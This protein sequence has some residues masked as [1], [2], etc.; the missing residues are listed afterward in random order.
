LERR[1]YRS[2]FQDG[3]WD[4]YLAGFMAIL[5]ILGLAHFRDGST[6]IWMIG[7]LVGIGGIFI[8]FMLGKKYI[9]VPRLGTAKFGPARK[10][11]KL[12]LVV[13]LSVSVLFNVVVLLITMGI[14]KA[15][16]WLQS[17]GDNLTQRG[18]MDVFISLFAGLFVTVIMCLIAYFIEFYR[19]MYIAFLFGLCIFID[20]FFDLPVA[21][22]VGE[23]L[24]AIPGLVLFIRFIKQYPIQRGLVENGNPKTN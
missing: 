23:A 12:G 17:F 8:L 21:M 24:A 4:L 6:W 2:T 15:P 20:M 13:I 5:G 16:V 22:L 19:G 11:R 1:A 18:V 7:Y 14:I 10:R 9:T 3:L